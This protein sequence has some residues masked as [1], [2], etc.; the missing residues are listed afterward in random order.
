MSSGGSVI[1][2]EIRALVCLIK[3]IVDL[4]IQYKELA[5]MRTADGKVH[6]VDLVIKDEFGKEIGFE[7]TEQGNYR[8]VSDSSGLNQNQIRKQQEFVKKIRQRYAYNKVVEELRKQGYTIA[9][10][11][12]VEKNTIRLVARKWS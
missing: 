1:A 2:L 7:K 4:G 8:I 9:E 3:S 10:E 6:K 11:E 12:K 5:S